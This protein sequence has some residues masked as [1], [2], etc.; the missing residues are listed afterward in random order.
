MIFKVLYQFF[1]TCHDWKED[2][3]CIVYSDFAYQLSTNTKGVNRLVYK[4]SL[5]GKKCDLQEEMLLCKRT[6]WEKETKLLAF[7]MVNY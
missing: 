1:S 3:F 6:K 2:H 5:I 4:F 7:F